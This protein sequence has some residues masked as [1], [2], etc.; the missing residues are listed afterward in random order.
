VAF[1]DVLGRL[2]ANGGKIEAPLGQIGKLIGTGAKTTTDRALTELARLGIT[3]GAGAGGT[4]VAV[5][6]LN[7][8][9]TSLAEHQ[10][11]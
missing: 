5:F 1:G 8:I 11:S 10:L 9:S 6:G 7:G 4:C 2:E 3:L